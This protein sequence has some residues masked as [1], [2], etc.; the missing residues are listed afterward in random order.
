MTEGSRSMAEPRK[1]EPKIDA[2]EVL[3]GIVEWVSIESPSHDAR[4]VNKVVDH[5]E[6]QFRDLGLKLE[7]IPG[8]DV[9]VDILESKTSPEMSQQSDGKGILVLAYLYTVHPIG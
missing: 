5:V 2:D 4:S 6:G 1:N 9:F 3:N 7:R 8:V